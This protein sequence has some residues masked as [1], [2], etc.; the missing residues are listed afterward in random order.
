MPI[1]LVI[2]SITCSPR[3]CRSNFRLQLLDFLHGL[4]VDPPHLLYIVPGGPFEVWIPEQG[5]RVVGHYGPYILII[6]YVLPEN[7][8]RGVALEEVLAGHPS[9]GTYEDRIKQLDLP[10]EVR[11]ACPYLFLV[12]IA[13]FGRPALEDIRDINLF[14]R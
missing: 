12:R 5:R 13:V 9:E 10:L 1:L 14:T 3:C 8:Q 7:R 4:V 11:L 6:V 2:S